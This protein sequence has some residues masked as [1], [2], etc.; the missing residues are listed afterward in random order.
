MFDLATDIIAS[1]VFIGLAI[2][3]DAMIATMLIAPSIANKKQAAYW[4][5]GITLTHVALPVIS[6]SSSWKSLEW[7]PTLAPILGVVAFTATAYLFWQWL[8]EALV[9]TSTNSDSNPITQPF[10]ISIWLI[11]TISLDALYSG[12]AIFG[13][14]QKQD[15]P[16]WATSIMFLFIGNLLALLL[17]ASLLLANSN[18]LNLRNL[19]SVKHRLWAVWLQTSAI[20]YFSLM[21]LFRLTFGWEIAS[22][23]V[24]LISLLLTGVLTMYYRKTSSTSTRVRALF[25]NF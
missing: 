25:Y 3:I 14:V 15:W 23:T 8:R 13:Q 10:V 22:L 20:G 7:F 21:A 17:T 1:A 18:W 16:I 12:P 19:I 2:G 4:I 24:L 6:F 5:L 11:I 9:A